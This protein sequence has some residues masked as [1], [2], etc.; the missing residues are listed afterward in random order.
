MPGG[1]YRDGKVVVDKSTVPVGT[2]VKVRGVTRDS[3]QGDVRLTELF[4]AMGCKVFQ[5]KDGLVERSKGS[6][7]YVKNDHKEDIQIE[8]SDKASKPNISF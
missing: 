3:R 5:E 1:E 6:G 7:V 4:E 8:E 2:A